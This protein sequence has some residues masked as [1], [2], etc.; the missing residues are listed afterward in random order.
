[1]LAYSALRSLVGMMTLPL[2]AARIIHHCHS[3]LAGFETA[4]SYCLFV[5]Y[6]LW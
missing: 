5:Y 3:H 1:M 4:L 6:Y 2:R